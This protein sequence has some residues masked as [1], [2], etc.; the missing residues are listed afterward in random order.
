MQKIKRHY[1]HQY[2][3]TYLHQ[4]KNNINYGKYHTLHITK[5]RKY[6]FTAHIILHELTCDPLSRRP[7]KLVLLSVA[8]L[9]DS[10][11]Y[12]IPERKS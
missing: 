7:T 2:S 3:K 1:T 8:T 11:S 12:Y 10:F 6:L 5:L 4:H 9:C